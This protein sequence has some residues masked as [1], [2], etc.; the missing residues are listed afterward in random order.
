[1]L[2]YMVHK[3]HVQFDDERLSYG[4]V[5]DRWIGDAEFRRHFVQ[6]LR[7]APPAAYRW[8]TPPVTNATLDR[9]FE[10]AL[11]DCPR[12]IRTPDESA[13]AEHFRAP[14]DETTVAVF[15]NI[16]G[17][18]V[19]VVPRPLKDVPPPIDNNAYVHLA[20]FVREGPPEQ[21]DAFWQAVGRAMR[22]RVDE[23][24][25]WLSTA[26]MGVA[27]LHVRLD[28]RPKYYAHGPYRK[29]N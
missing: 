21:V 3:Y 22:E 5:I 15:P 23:S 16:G 25:T 19:L 7:D 12:L 28:R 13:F 20:A 14:P 26:G 17:D 11:V 4:E 27:W 1:M 6:L 8:E 18:A 10:F 29:V 2:F 24:P 9:Q